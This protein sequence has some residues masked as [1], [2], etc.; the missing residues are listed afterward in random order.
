MSLEQLSAIA[1]IL[2]TAVGI[3]SLIFVGIRS[4]S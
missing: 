1:Q 2:A 3:P 4:C